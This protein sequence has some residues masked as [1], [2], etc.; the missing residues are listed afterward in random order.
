MEQFLEGSQAYLDAPVGTVVEDRFGIAVKVDGDQWRGVA[1]RWRGVLSRTM[2]EYRKVVHTFRLGETI[3]AKTRPWLPPDAKVEDGFLIEFP[4][5]GRALYSQSNYDSALVG[6][7]VKALGSD[8]T[9][10]KT[11][12]G[13]EPPNGRLIYESSDL[14]N[15][16]RVVVDRYAVG[17]T[18]YS[19]ADYDNAPVGTTVGLI[20]GAKGYWVKT[21]NGWRGPKGEERIFG[22]IGQRTILNPM[23]EWELDLRYGEAPEPAADPRVDGERTVKYSHNKAKG[24][25]YA[26][27]G[28]FAH[29]DFGRIVKLS[30]SRFLA[31]PNRTPREFLTEQDAI[32]YLL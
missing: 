11:W 31:V 5:L 2:M 13:W 23:P 24:T 28:G 27:D 21:V 6:T 26:Y 22:M 25:V 12:R 16:P 15:W 29:R 1:G 9:L 20:G 19:K 10:T 14:A 7:A 8:T 17:N 32:N 18:L 3:T 30:D 4:G